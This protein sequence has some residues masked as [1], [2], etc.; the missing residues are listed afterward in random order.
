MFLIS[1]TLFLA[2]MLAFLAAIVLAL[3][4]PHSFTL[5]SKTDI[6]QGELGLA[7]LYAGLAIAG[8]VIRTPYAYHR[9]FFGFFFLSLLI[10]VVLWFLILRRDMGV[11]AD[12]M[13][14]ICLCVMCLFFVMA[15]LVRIN[16][17]ADH[18]EPETFL[19]EIEDV[20]PARNLR[21][22]CR[23]PSPEG[24][25]LCYYRPHY[26]KPNIG[27]KVVLYKHH[28]ALGLPYYRYESL[29]ETMP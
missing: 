1:N 3:V 25:D 21:Y 6:R 11:R 29:T 8:N 26:A 18:R 7:F 23:I 15:G 14:S 12:A 16:I 24:F 17:L 2:S 22:G 13:S 19:S 5:G 4:F 10:N 20:W 28:G 27:E 9:A